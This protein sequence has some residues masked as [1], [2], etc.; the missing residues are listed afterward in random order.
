MGW[1]EDY[2]NKYSQASSPINQKNVAWDAINNAHKYGNLAPQ[3]TTAGSGTSGSSTSAGTPRKHRSI[4]TK[5]IDGLSAGSY[6]ANAALNSSLDRVGKGG[7]DI[8][9]LN[10]I[11]AAKDLITKFPGGFEAGFTGDKSK[12]ILGKDLIAKYDPG[13]GNKTKA[14]GGLGIDILADPTTYVPGLDLFTGGKKIVK[15]AKGVKELTAPATKVAEDVTP[16]LAPVVDNIARDA[17]GKQLALPAALPS[18]TRVASTTGD[19]GAVGS[20]LARIIPAPKIGDLAIQPSLFDHLMGST[21]RIGEKTAE[22]TTPIAETIAEQASMFR[23]QGKGFSPNINALTGPKDFIPKVA[24]KVAPKV[25]DQILTAPVAKAIEPTADHIAVLSRM[26]NPERD[27]NLLGKGINGIK[28]IS[29]ARIH[30]A[31]LGGRA[32]PAGLKIQARKDI[33]TTVDE[34]KAKLLREVTPVIAQKEIAQT[35]D[36]AISGATEIAAEIAPKFVAKEDPNLIQASAQI[37][38]K[39]IA[40]IAENKAAKGYVA[41][42]YTAVH[43]ANALNEAIQTADKYI[44]FINPNIK[45][46]ASIKN[47]VKTRFATTLNVLRTSEQAIEK[48]GHSALAETGPQAATA[49][50]LSDV[51][52]RLGPHA[53]FSTDAPLWTHLLNAVAGNQKDLAKLP[54]IL[55]A[56]IANGEFKDLV[57]KAGAHKLA[58][59]SAVATDAANSAINHLGILDAAPTGTPGE[60]A[61]AAA[62]APGVAKAVAQAAGGSVTA[63][64]M[65]SRSTKELLQ[66]AAKTEVPGL[67]AAARKVSAKTPESRIAANIAGVKAA[68]QIAGVSAEDLSKLKP[69]AIDGTIQAYLG[70]MFKP[71]FGHSDLHHFMREGMDLSKQLR[72]QSHT[73]LLAIGKMGTKDEIGLAFKA[74]QGHTAVSGKSSE[75]LN[76]MTGFMD[77]LLTHGGI[78][79]ASTA[80]LQRERIN[81][82]DLNTAMRRKGW[83]IPFG[84]KVTDIVTGKPIKLD[85]W[86]DAWKHMPIKEPLEFLNKLSAAT[87]DVLGEKA[88]WDLTVKNFGRKGATQVGDVA[89]NGHNALDGVYFPRDIAPQVRAMNNAMLRLKGMKSG[90]PILRALDKSMNLWK[91]SLTK[92]MPS[93]HIRNAIGDAFMNFL[94]G[95]INPKY[96]ARAVAI[97]ANPNGTKIAAKIGSREF[98]QAEIHMAAFKKGIL[99]SANAIEDIPAGVDD[100]IKG[101]KPFNGKVGHAVATVS[102]GRE[103]TFRYAQFIHEA[104]KHGGDPAVAFDHAARMVRRWHPDGLDMTSFERQA[105][106]RVIPFYSWQRKAIP[107][108]LESMLTRPGKVIVYNKTQ[109]AL[110]TAMGVEG[111]PFP[112]DQLFP[113]WMTDI[114]IGPMF[115]SKAGNYWI[116]NPSNPFMDTAKML[117]NPGQAGAGMLNPLLRIPHDLMARSSKTPKGIDSSMGMPIQDTTQYIDKQIPGISNIN[118][119]LGTDI[120]AGSLEALATGNPGAMLSGSVQKGNS[121]VGDNA[122]AKILNILTAGGIQNAST[123]GVK[124]SGQYDLTQRLLKKG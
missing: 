99:P 84:H 19:I 114:P 69:D 80:A 40:K 29:G 56:R 16:A 121:Q 104:E 74:L 91:T 39:Q 47:L 37:A 51:F 41:G 122:A 36:A 24:K 90:P 44:K 89:F 26:F 50:R 35:A 45:N 81:L 71:D 33:V 78:S 75:I 48:A 79:D 46:P 68:E 11:Y 43:Q 115:K 116:V 123:K 85:N 103:H 52:E 21:S 22:D 10:V 83:D 109:T 118:S 60:L 27:Y 12:Q 20:K 105:M 49:L 107:L 93:H 32:L 73:A 9:G 110:Q 72:S 94:S 108:M 101:F 2:L 58:Q 76:E 95:T 86:L 92:Y 67:A 6:G 4:L 17:A 23:P 57:V 8:P 63:V 13:A 77:N 117:N 70:T 3:I 82:E 55:Q 106:R 31:I 53:A 87:Q 42:G 111:D 100:A 112:T 88:V 98:T 25:S 119:I 62:S 38:E 96:T 124:K 30:E 5:I 28:A 66:N 61:R 59:D 120:G 102:E 54:T 97:I 7:S 15:F 18:T 65:A 1:V 64:E 14:L 113:N 34:A